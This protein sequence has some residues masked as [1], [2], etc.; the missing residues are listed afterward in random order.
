MHIQNTQSNGAAVAVVTAA[1]GEL[2]IT[3]PQSALE[4]MMTVQYETGAA[5]LVLD[6][7]AVSEDFF[8]LSTGIAGEI[9]Q[10]FINYGVK[11]AFFGDYSRYTSQPLRDFIRE[12]NRGRDFLFVATQAEALQKLAD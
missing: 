11:A 1:P 2:L 12:S 7:R 4:L 9:L 5:R 6:K 8:V 10:K 3:D